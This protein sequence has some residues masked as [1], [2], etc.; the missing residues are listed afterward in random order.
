[1]MEI[2]SRKRMI[3]IAKDSLSKGVHRKTVSFQFTD[4]SLILLSDGDEEIPYF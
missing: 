1:M 2:R 3:L 4:K